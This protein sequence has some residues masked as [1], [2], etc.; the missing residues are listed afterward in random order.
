M[1]AAAAQAPSTAAA[2]A[3]AGRVSAEVRSSRIGDILRRFS[4]DLVEHER[5]FRQKAVQVQDW[6]RRVLENA[7]QIY[8]LKR[9]VDETER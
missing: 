3:A 1:S 6:D 7:D 5:D 2:A 4:N 8:R 9:L